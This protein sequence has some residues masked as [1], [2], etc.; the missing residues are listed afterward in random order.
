MHPQD[1]APPPPWLDEVL[2]ALVERRKAGE[3]QGLERVELDPK[4]GNWTPPLVIVYEGIGEGERKAVKEL[5][6]MGVEVVSGVGRW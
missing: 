2:R 5:S 4:G 3:L 6:G 1:S